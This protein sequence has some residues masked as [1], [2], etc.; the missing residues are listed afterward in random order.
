MLRLTPTATE[1][2]NVMMGLDGRPADI[3]LLLAITNSKLTGAID[4]TSLTRLEFD[5]SVTDTSATGTLVGRYSASGK[6]LDINDGASGAAVATM[7]KD[8]AG[9]YVGTL[10]GTLRVSWP[11]PTVSCAS[12]T[13]RIELIKLVRID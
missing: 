9:I 13:N 5:L 6:V 3:P 8:A 4:S 7:S 12:A 1:C 10:S 11:G 2:H